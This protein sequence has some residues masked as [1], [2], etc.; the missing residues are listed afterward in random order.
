MAINRI[1]IKGEVYYEDTYRLTDRD[2]VAVVRYLSGVISDLTEAGV[3]EEQITVRS[4]LDAA[5]YSV[6]IEVYV[7][8]RQAEKLGWDL[9]KADLRT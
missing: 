5:P 3:S 1:T 4:E 9:V 8:D 6:E 2:L 7:T